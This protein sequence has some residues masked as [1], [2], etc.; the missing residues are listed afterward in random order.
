MTTSRGKKMALA[1]KTK[2][3]LAAQPQ[4]LK[5]QRRDVGGSFG[6]GRVAAVALMAAV[7]MASV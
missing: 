5:Q 2:A 4:Q 6:G 7:A 3:A 1:R